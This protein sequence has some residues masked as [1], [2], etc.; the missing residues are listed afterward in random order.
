MH[1]ET[2]AAAEDRAIFRSGLRDHISK[3][4]S[5]EYARAEHDGKSKANRASWQELSRELDLLGLSLPIE[6]GGSGLSRAE[7]ALVFEEFG[8][9]LVPLPMLATVGLASETILAT[10]CDVAQRRYLPAIVAG[11]SIAAVAIADAG[12]CLEESAI[13][14]TAKRVEEQDTWQLNGCKRLVLDATSADV[15]LVAARS[16]RG[17]SLFAVDPDQPGV[18]ITRQHGIDPTRKPSTLDLLDAKA[19]LV[20]D[21]GDAWPAIVR[22]LDISCVYLAAEMLGAAAFSVEQTVAYTTER[23]Q[24]GQPIGSFQAVQH[25]CAGM[26]VQLEL[27][28]SSLA[29]ALDSFAGSSDLSLSVHASIAKVTCGDAFAAIANDAVQIHGGAGF[30]WEH[31]AHLFL[32]RAKGD[33]YMLGTP[34]EHRRRIAHAVF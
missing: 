19:E 3:R 17:V 20:G 15:I 10:G 31:H 9:A 13:T 28:R 6:F 26:Y 14:S 33:Q 27:A 22:G 30:T 23:I 24:F 21:E 34:S 5:L 12:C 1:Q 32:K 11:D 29:A 8:R 7:T 18:R 2:A 25:R 4:Y 16:N